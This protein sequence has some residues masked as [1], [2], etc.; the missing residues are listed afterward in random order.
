MDW[1]CLCFHLL[2]TLLASIVLDLTGV[3][4]MR[5]SILFLSLYILSRI[6]LIL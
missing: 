5:L 3:K 2:L 6:V 4:K 1:S